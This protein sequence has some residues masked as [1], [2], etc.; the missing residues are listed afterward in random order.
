MAET[1][2]LT[3]ADYE[4]LCARIED[5]E[6]SL[7]RMAAR[8]ENG[9]RIP[10]EVLAAEIE[11]EHPIRAWRKHRGLSARDLAARAELTAAYLSEI[12][13]GKKPGSLDAFRT[14]ANVLEVPLDLL[15]PE[16]APDDRAAR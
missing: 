14:I 7:A 16:N 2:T 8:L 10:H 4:A 3:R 9:P 1:V 15:V 5:L 13:T 12:E 6:D 11:G